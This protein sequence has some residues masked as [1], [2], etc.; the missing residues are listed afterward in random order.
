MMGRSNKT[1]F[2]IGGK[3]FQLIYNH[4]GTSPNKKHQSIY[5]RCNVCPHHGQIISSLLS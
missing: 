1:L 4:N 5:P 2:Y 3:F